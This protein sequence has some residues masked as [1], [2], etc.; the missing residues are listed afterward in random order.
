VTPLNRSDRALIAE[1][2]GK[3]R[4]LAETHRQYASMAGNAAARS[5][6]ADGAQRTARLASLIARLAK[7]AP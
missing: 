5:C 7:A 3:L 6:A 4:D 1:H 2:V